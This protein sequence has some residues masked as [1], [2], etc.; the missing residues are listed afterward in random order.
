MASSG[1][2]VFGEMSYQEMIKLIQALSP[3]YRTVFNLHVIEGYS[4]EEIAKLLGIS[5]GA[6]K[7]NLSRARENLRSMLTK[8]HEKGLAKH[9]R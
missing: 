7:S 6:S 2:D 8:N 9:E 4:H 1:Q 5:V 3:V